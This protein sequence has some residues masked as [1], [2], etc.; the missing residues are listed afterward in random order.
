VQPCRGER[1][2]FLTRRYPVRDVM[3]ADELQKL[4]LSLPGA[5]LSIQWGNDRVYKVGGKMFACSGEET[6]SAYSFKV[7]VTVPPPG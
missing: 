5:T 2:L 6:D 7:E 4:C 1:L 3:N